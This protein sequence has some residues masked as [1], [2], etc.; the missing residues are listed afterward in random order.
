MEQF[1][2]LWNKISKAKIDPK[3][4]N[5]VVIENFFLLNILILFRKET[6]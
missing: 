1:D 4:F 3:P 2:Y 6:Y 5:H